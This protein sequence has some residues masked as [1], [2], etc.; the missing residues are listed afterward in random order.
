M[1]KVFIISFSLIIFSCD[2]ED[3]ASSP[4]ATIYGCTDQFA[5]NYD[6]DATDDNAS[7]SYDYCSINCQLPDKVVFINELENNELEVWY[8]TMNP[9][10]GFQFDI[11]G[12]DINGDILAEDLEN[13][14]LNITYYE[15]SNE[16]FTRILGHY[17]LID[18]NEELSCV[19]EAENGCI[20]SGC[21]T[22]LKFSYQGTMTGVSNIIFGGYMGN[23]ITIEY[24]SP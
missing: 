9:F 24:H 15:F 8:N 16:G 21:G 20:L 7:C 17:N 2:K 3:P 13:I 12:I 5:C 14:G 18:I 6:T 4:P 11:Y 1:Y 23:P 10:F 19:D 22:L